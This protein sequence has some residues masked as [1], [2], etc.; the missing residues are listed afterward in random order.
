M[1]GG[2]GEAAQGVSVTLPWEQWGL[3]AGLVGRD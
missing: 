2:T 3:M 1:R